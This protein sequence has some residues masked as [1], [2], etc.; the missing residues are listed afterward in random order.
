MSVGLTKSKSGNEKGAGRMF[1]ETKTF[2]VSE[3]NA[4]KVVERFSK[5]GIIE[6]SPGFIDLSVLEKKTRRGEEEVIVFIRWESEESWKNWEKS[7][8]H[9]A[10]HRQNRGKPKPEH[11]I[12]VTH[13][14]YEVKSTKTAVTA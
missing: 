9:I 1:V 4:H 11:I 12:N 14:T 2:T 8:A 10:M 6:K 3:G 7:E 13:G 5:E